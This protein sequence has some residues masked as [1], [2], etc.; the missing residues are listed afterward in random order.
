MLV[1]Q[2]LGFRFPMC[3]VH[4]VRVGH[5]QHWEGGPHK[6]DSETPRI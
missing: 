3:H 6:I 5:V 1:L 2:P 4:V